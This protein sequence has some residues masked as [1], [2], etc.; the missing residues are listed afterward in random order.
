MTI[1]YIRDLKC[2]NENVDSLNKTIQQHYKKKDRGCGETECV[3]KQMIWKE[4][5]YERDRVWKYRG[6]GRR[7]V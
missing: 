2:K 7:D 4:R 5:G 1:F 6:C 3:H